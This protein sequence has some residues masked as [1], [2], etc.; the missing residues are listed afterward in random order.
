MVLMK[1][2]LQLNE[3]LFISLSF[4]DE[5]PVEE[6]QRRREPRVGVLHPPAAA[7]AV[8]R[9]LRGSRHQPLLAGAARSNKQHPR[10]RRPHRPLGPVRSVSSQM[11][12]SH[13]TVDRTEISRQ[14]SASTTKF[15]CDRTPGQVHAVGPAPELGQHVQHPTARPASRTV[16]I[17][18][19]VAQGQH[20]SVR[21]YA[22]VRQ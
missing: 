11:P 16:P 21:W 18:L 2:N 3:L 22:D 15:A 8:D 7:P 13:T 12:C 1:W 19:Q 6:P 10:E 20:R 14:Y 5:S 17:L 9:E 4:L